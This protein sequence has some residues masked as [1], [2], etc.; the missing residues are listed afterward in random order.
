MKATLNFVVQG[1]VL[2]HI[3]YSPNLLCCLEGQKCSNEFKV[4]I[5]LSIKFLFARI[6]RFHSDAVM[7][8]HAV[9][10]RV[11]IFQRRLLPMCSGEQKK[12]DN[13]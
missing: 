5:Y 12:S 9:W 11:K 10:C 3:Q 6:A 4:I 8:S 1:S 2:L 13:G 7:R